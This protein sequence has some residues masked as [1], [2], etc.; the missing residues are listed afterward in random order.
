MQQYFEPHLPSD[1]LLG[2]QRPAQRIRAHRRQQISAHCN[3]ELLKCLLRPFSD[4]DTQRQNGATGSRLATLRERAQLSPS[5]GAV[6][7]CLTGTRRKRAVVADV[8]IVHVRHLS[9]SCVQAVRAAMTH[10]DNYSARPGNL[11][12]GKLEDPVAAAYAPACD[13]LVTAGFEHLQASVV[14]TWPTETTREL[15]IMIIY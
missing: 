1:V 7:G 2:V 10:Y 15:Q 11:H 12:E 3:T 4:V 9:L 14:C 13:T 8:P 6:T 5:S